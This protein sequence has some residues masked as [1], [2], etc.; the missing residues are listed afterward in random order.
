MHSCIYV[1]QVS[2]RRFFPRE[3]R[4]SYPLFMMYLDLDELP[5]LFKPFWLWS[6]RPPAPACFRRRDHLGAPGTDLATAARDLVEQ[7]LGRRPAGPVRLLTH[8]AYF[9]YRFN[10][11]SVYYCFEAD[12]E[13]PAAFIL[14]VNNTPWG[15]QHCY[16]LDAAGGGPRRFRFR[17]GKEFHVSPFLPM[18]MDYDWYLT[19]PQ[20]KLGLVMVNYHQGRRCFDA[21]LSLE[22]REISHAGLAGVLLRFPF[23]TLR[24]IIA[25]YSQALRLWLKRIPFH[26]HPGRR[27][28]PAGRR[29]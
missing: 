27:A 18:D 7:R 22:R 3:H 14:E 4:F 10:P 16:V 19:L 8:L 25:I 20:R 1:G 2:H 23:M 12:G 17:R 28:N 24:I 15:E 5:T 29:P 9:G 13:T 11:V 6:H 26:P 21:G